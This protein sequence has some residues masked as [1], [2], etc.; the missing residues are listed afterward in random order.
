MLHFTGPFQ[1]VNNVA[2]NLE[3]VWK[4]YYGMV[5]QEKNVF[6]TF[7]LLVVAYHAFWRDSKCA[8]KIQVAKHRIYLI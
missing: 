4:N 7:Y 5:T 6:H 2:L 8:N 1:N 3:M